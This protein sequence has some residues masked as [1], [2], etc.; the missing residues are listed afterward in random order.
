MFEHL[1]AYS[2]SGPTRGAQCKIKQNIRKHD[3][4]L[5]RKFL[6]S[7]RKKYPGASAFVFPDARGNPPNIHQR[8]INVL[9]G[10]TDDDVEFFHSDLIF[11]FSLFALPDNRK[12]LTIQRDLQLKLKN[13]WC[14][15]IVWNLN[16][17]SGMIH[18]TAILKSN[19][20]E[21]AFH[22]EF[23]VSHFYF[24]S[25][26]IKWNLLFSP[27][28]A[29][30][31][32]FWYIFTAQCQH[33]LCFYLYC[34]EEALISIL[35]RTKKCNFVSRQLVISCDMENR[36]RV[37]WEQNHIWINYYVVRS[38][39]WLLVFVLPFRVLPCFQ[40]CPVCPWLNWIFHRF[41][42]PLKAWCQYFSP[43]MW[44][45]ISA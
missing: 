4:S 34:R 32:F 24:R 10:P 17:P 41:D 37:N 40:I 16:S 14:I 31:S 44:R 35:M 28:G 5:L 45:G 20:Y 27:F 23:L 30:P 42:G 3:I 2:I 1:N 6:L 9:R 15:K 18:D 7:R 39:N 13:E 11:M 36:I 19:L 43:I 12:N 25:C 29:S 21:S 8:Y 33:L 38:S 22:G 26:F